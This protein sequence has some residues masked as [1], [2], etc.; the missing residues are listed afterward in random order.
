MVDPNHSTV[1]LITFYQE[2]IYMTKARCIAAPTPQQLLITLVLLLG[3]TFTFICTV[4]SQESFPP[5]PEAL[6]AME[7]DEDVTVSVVTVVVMPAS[8][9]ATLI[10]MRTRMDRMRQ[11]SRLISGEAYS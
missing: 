10:T 2:K 11:T 5:L 8:V 4:S 3:I 9:R 7:S 1:Y 6:A